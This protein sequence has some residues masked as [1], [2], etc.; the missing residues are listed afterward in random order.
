MNKC[1]DITLG[2]GVRIIFKG[3]DKNDFKSSIPPHDALLTVIRSKYS[4]VRIGFCIVY[5]LMNPTSPTI[6]LWWGYRV[7]LAVQV[8]IRRFSNK[9]KATAILFKIKDRT[10][11]GGMN[12]I[13]N[14]YKNILQHSV[15]RPHRA[16]TWNLGGQGL[17]LSP[18]F[19]FDVPASVRV[20][21]ETSHYSIEHDPIFHRTGEFA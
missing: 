19:S 20:V 16:A 8:F 9:S 10:F 15:H 18:K 6:P 2:S 5:E 14:L 17:L 12:D 21:L 13:H 11:N 4:I 7:F 3:Q 1:D